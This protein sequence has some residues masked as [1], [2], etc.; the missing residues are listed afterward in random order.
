[1]IRFFDVLLSLIIL[2]IVIP[3]L[4]VVYL[5]GYFDLGSP[6]F[7][8]VRMGKDKKTFLLIK[9]RTMHLDTKSVPT[10]LVNKNAITKFGK[11]LRISKIDELPQLWNVL[12]GNMSLVGPRPNLLTQKDVIFERE[13][14]NVYSVKPGITGLAQIN[15]IDMSAPKLLAETDAKMVND[16]S[17]VQYFKFIFLTIIRKILRINYN[18]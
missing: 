2:T 16:F 13:K 9:F 1:M 7:S 14:L 17:L 6:L 3:L 18:N 12:K 11:F 8:Q 10:H 15:K 4:V 5:I